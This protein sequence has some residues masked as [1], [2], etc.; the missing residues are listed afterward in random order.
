MRISRSNFFRSECS[1]VLI[2]L[3]VY[4]FSF[5]GFSR[6][7]SKKILK[8]FPAGTRPFDHNPLA[9]SHRKRH[10]K[11]ECKS[12]SET[13]YAGKARQKP[14]TRIGNQVYQPCTFTVFSLLLFSPA[15]CFVSGIVCF[16]AIEFHMGFEHSFASIILSPAQHSFNRALRKFI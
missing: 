15:V 9:R 16:I 1:V 5:Q 7:V 2:V 14:D 8:P 12:L 3:S 13:S 4:S 11:S 6:S 10:H